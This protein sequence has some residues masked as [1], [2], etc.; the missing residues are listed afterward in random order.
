[1][2][3]KHKI[4]ML[5]IMT[6]VIVT[7]GIVINWG[8]TTRASNGLAKVEQVQYP[9]VEALRS[10]RSNVVAVQE[11]LQRAV[12]EGD[13]GAIESA[14]EYAQQVVTTLEELS[15]IDG[16]DQ[17]LIR[18]LRERFDEYSTA[19]FRAVRTLMEL[20]KGDSG[21][22][23]ARMQSASETLTTLLTQSSDEAVR[24]FQTLLTNGASDVRKTLSVSMIAAV[25][26]LLVLGVGSAVLIS[27][28]FRS[29]GGE[30]EIAV[31]VVRSIAGGDFTTRVD[32]RS[33]DDSSLLH[34]IA[35]LR[36]KLGSLIRDVHDCSE[37]VDTAARNMNEAVRDLSERTAQQA[38]NLEQTATSMEE[39]TTTV[40][41]NADN[42]HVASELAS[43]ARTQA[44][45]GGQVVDKAVQAMSEINES[46]RRIADIIG[47]IDEIAFQTN[48][49]ALN[50]AVEA[51]R[52]GEQGRG[53]AVVAVEV[54]N[55]AQRSGTA[56][57]EIKTLIQDSVAKVQDGTALVDASGR[58]LNDIVVSVKKVADIISAISAAGQEQARGLEHV[59]MAVTEMDRATQ[60]NSA[61]VEETFAVADT[62]QGQAKQLMD[63]I[64]MFRVE[65]RNHAP[66]APRTCES[67]EADED[68]ARSLRAA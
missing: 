48:L 4:W 39:M 15:R 65:G 33:D 19:A 49:L 5:P 25:A 54:R 12:A 22:A 35:M 36:D 28:V 18:E 60:E 42:A 1:V 61:M 11:S 68:E 58:H 27:S 64:S 10:V 24:E 32:V 31:E 46:S 17:A 41:E 43:A 67:S 44:E 30:P 16:T 63:L 3:F 56:A 59:N 47:V 34:G 23:V 55:L 52:A 26:M 9:T 29:L 62:M 37:A 57:R 50:A 40:K 2:R 14:Q 8:I 6:A 21:R 7:A 38:A 66:S 53:F 13:A 51:A 45:T 20:E